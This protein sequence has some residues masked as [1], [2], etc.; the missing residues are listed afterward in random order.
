MQQ[1]PCRILFVEDHEDTRQVISLLLELDGYEVT[2]VQTVAEGAEL[3]RDSH[4]DLYLFD[5]YLPDGTGIELC[6]RVRQFDSR[7]PILF[8]SGSDFKDDEKQARTAGAQAYVTKPFDSEKLELA[9]LRLLNRRSL[10]SV[11]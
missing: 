4:F 8:C 1:V 10:G 11:A 6:Q 5:N 2:A 3:A 9:I 7:T